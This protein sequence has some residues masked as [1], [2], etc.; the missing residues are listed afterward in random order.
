MKGIEEDSY[1]NLLSAIAKGNQQAFTKLYD[2]F[3][4]D[5]IRFVTAKVNDQSSAEDILHD[6][7]L[8]LW[9]SRHRI[10]E[11]E[12]L[13]AYLY[14]SCRYL[15]IG[16]IKKTSV[17]NTNEDL[18][19][20]DI[21]YEETSLEDRLHYRYLLDMVNLEIENLPEKCR[22]IFK[23]SREELKSNKQIAEY[24]GISESTVENQINKA[25]K[26]IRFATKKLFFFM[27]IFC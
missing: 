1:G 10:E 12:S 7:F 17:W 27:T 11:I 8:S 6:L 25:L 14:S 3:Y 4:P 18:S 19:D 2:L 20:L 15:I 13:S 5:L 22:E 16:H 23:L 21:Q 24:L 9:K 26:R